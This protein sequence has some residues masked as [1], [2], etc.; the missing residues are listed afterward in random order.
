M[1]YPVTKSLKSV[2]PLEPATITPDHI[3]DAVLGVIQSARAQGQSLDD[4]T[5]EVLADDA[6][7]DVRIRHLL[8]D[9]VRE[10]WTVVP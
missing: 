10:A 9:I 8:S 2:A 4:I 7:L 5:A 1:E 3:A 6:M